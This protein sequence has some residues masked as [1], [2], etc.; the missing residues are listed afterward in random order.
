MRI[1]YFFYNIVFY[2]NLFL[3]IYI[4]L[5]KVNILKDNFYFF[6]FC[7]MLL[8]FKKYIIFSKKEKVRSL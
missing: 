2:I 1:I 4:N 5:V 6:L 8:I 7:V 3:V